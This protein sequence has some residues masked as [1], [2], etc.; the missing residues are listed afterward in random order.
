[1]IAHVL[2]CQTCNAEIS[3]GGG[4]Y[5][6]AACATKVT[7]ARLD[8]VRREIDRRTPSLFRSAYPDAPELAA[9][10]T[11][12]TAISTALNEPSSRQ[13]IFLGP[14][15]TGKT[16]LARTTLVKRV[17]AD[18]PVAGREWKRFEPDWQYDDEHS[19]LHIPA[20]FVTT[21]ALAKARREQRLGAGEAELI[22]S[23]VH[24]RHLLLDE[25]GAE[26]ARGDTVVGEVLHERHAAELATL[27]TT[28]FSFDELGTKYGGGIVRRV[29]E[30]ALVIRLGAK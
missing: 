12:P 3:D 22:E 1:M 2:R 24:V 16:T 4:T 14:S 26:A 9:R 25:L 13:I 6:C 28:P 15:G 27:I 8:R 17:L 19:S 11:P 21:F 20:L 10:V 30:R 7:T 29:F 5:R 18:V 23:A